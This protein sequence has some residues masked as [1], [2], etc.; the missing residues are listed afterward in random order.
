MDGYTIEIDQLHNDVV[1]LVVPALRLVVFGR[2]MREALSR[3]RASVAFR[4][5]EAG[6]PAC[7]LVSAAGEDRGSLSTSRPP[8]RETVGS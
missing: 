5:L 1:V 2:T 4:G 8:P 7:C 6:N 3:A